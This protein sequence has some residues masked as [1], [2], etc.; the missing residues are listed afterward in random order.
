MSIKVIV[1]FQARPGMRDE[2][3]STLGGIIPEHGPRMAGYFGSA[4][5]TIVH[6][7]DMPLENPE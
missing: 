7:A 3:V 2:L 1:G 4:P 5:D 6:R